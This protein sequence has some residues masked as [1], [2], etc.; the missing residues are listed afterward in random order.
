[1]KEA[2]ILERIESLEAGLRQI[3][4]W[5]LKKEMESCKNEKR[6]S[7]FNRIIKKSNKK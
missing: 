5:L 2:T 7:W 1:M 6:V 3:K 4:G